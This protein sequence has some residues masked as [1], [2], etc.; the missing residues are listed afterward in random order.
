MR[1]FQEGDIIR[2]GSYY[3]LVIGGSRDA[4]SLYHIV[5]LTHRGNFRDDVV[6]YLEKNIF[7]VYDEEE[8]KKY[9]KICNIKEAL[10][11]AFYKETL[12]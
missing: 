11:E 3:Y 12:K 9:T 10:H 5:H 7:N 6:P 1:F 8:C 4:S 2:N